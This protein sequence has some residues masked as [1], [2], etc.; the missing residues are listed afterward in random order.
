MKTIINRIALGVILLV[1]V[2]FSGDKSVLGHWYMGFI[3]YICLF[4]VIN[5]ISTLERKTEN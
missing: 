4:L 1:V 3:S 5:Y 2:L